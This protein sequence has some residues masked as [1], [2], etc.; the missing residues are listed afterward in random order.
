MKIALAQ[1]NPVIADIGGNRAKLIACIERAKRMGAELVVFPEMATIGYPPMDLLENHRLIDDNLAS[2]DEVAAACT[3]IAAVCG[4]VDYDRENAPMLFNSAAFLADGR[5]NSKLT[6]NMGLRYDINV[7][8]REKYGRIAYFDPTAPHPLATRAGL[9]NLAGLL[10]WI[11]EE[12]EANQQSSPRTNFA[13]RFGFAYKLSQ[14]S[15]LRGGY[16]IFFAPRNIQG[17]GT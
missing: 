5:V 2:L 10:R 8:N 3:G 9:P 14:S 12:N 16:G 6:L 1:I 17:N 7:G 15:V 11:G 4:Y 13:P